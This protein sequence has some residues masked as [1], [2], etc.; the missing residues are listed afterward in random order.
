MTAN[1]VDIYRHFGADA[2]KVLLGRLGLSCRNESSLNT[3]NNT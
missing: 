2:E 1:Y 3:I